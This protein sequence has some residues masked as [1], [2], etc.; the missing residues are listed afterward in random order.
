M[1]MYGKKLM[2]RDNGKYKGHDN[3]EDMIN[4]GDT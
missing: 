2:S 1:Y 4:S 3:R